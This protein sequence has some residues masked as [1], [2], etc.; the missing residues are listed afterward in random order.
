MVFEMANMLKQ[1]TGDSS[2]HQLHRN[3]L[4]RNEPSED[5]YLEWKWYFS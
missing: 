3:A 4:P 5:S 1:R 2:A